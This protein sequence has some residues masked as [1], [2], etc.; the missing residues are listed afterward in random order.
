[1]IGKQYDGEL[2]NSGFE[3]DEFNAYV[4][5]GFNETLNT[6]PIA[7]SITIYESTNLE[8]G[9]EIKAI[10]Q[11]N[12]S[13]IPASTNLRQIIG[14]REQFNTG[15][16][17][18]YQDKY[19][20]INSA[21]GNNQIYAKSTMILCNYDLKFLDSYGQPISRPCVIEITSTTS[22][23]K[24]TGTTNQMELGITQF[25][26]K[27]PF[28]TQTT[29]L[30]RNYDDGKER[31]LLIDYG[32]S[33]PKAYKIELCDRV[34][35]PGLINLTV[36]ECQ[37]SV[38]D[39]IELMIADYYD[40]VSPVP[41]L[42]YASPTCEISY[43]DKPLLIVGQGYKKFTAI[44]KDEHGE[45][46]PNETPIWNIF[47][48]DETLLPFLISEIDDNYIKIKATDDKLIGKTI[49]LELANADATLVC[50]VDLEVDFIG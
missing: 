37:G 24:T 17:V 42:Q 46:T 25:Y 9:S 33:K 21:V 44:F 48:E 27:L 14:K 16:Y 23:T 26:I 12:T 10:I 8:Y 29:L 38:N 32:T 28:D 35:Y 36:T 2:Y 43:I 50:R 40:R 30:D 49:K 45:V 47:I 22:G 7:N 39:N 18:L 13:D 20:L 4:V 5:D 6:S 41:F 15:N 3:K 11:N 1:L 34:T 19:W 31:R